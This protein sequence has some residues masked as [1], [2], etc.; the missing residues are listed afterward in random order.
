MCPLSNQQEKVHKDC[1][2]LNVTTASV[3]NS[4]VVRPNTRSPKR[5]RSS[6]RKVAVFIGRVW[7]QILSGHAMAERPHHCRRGK[8]G[9]T[10]PQKSRQDTWEGEEG[11]EKGGGVDEVR[12][13]RVHVHHLLRE[14]QERVEDVQTSVTLSD[15]RRGTKTPTLSCH[16][17]HFFETRLRTE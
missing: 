6:R 15:G 9:G 10:P 11:K 17:P 8:P 1:E 2:T 16:I 5:F 3:Q 13:T 4:T 12:V 14:P 7:F